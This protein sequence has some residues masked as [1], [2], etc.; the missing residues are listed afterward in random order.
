MYYVVTL[1]SEGAGP[2]A[3]TDPVPE[4]YCVQF[5]VC[6][7]SAFRQL[8]C[9]G[10]CDAVQCGAIAVR[11]QGRHSGGSRSLAQLWRSLFL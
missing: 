3:G 5:Y 6:E 7:V 9:V 10:N 4:T 8:P 1:D 2:Q 11:I